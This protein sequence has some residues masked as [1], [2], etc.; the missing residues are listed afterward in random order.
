MDSG[1]EMKVGDEVIIG[2]TDWYGCLG[3]RV[4]RNLKEK[5]VGELGLTR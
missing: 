5:L 3:F 1:L 4:E 2:A